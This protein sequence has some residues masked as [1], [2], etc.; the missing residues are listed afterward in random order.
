[1][2]LKDLWTGVGIILTTIDGKILMQL[3]EY[4]PKILFPGQWCVFTGRVEKEDW[5]GGTL[6]SLER[7]VRREIGEELIVKTD[8][9]PVPFSPD[10]ISL[11]YY[12][13]YLFPG[14][15]E[16]SHQFTFTGEI[17]APLE[18]LELKEGKELGVFGIEDMGRLK[19]ADSYSDVINLYLR[20]NC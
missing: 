16:T 12:K 7:A 18:S 14:K 8:N 11:F 10:K 1:M 13:P 17:Y 9:G 6:Q 20:L 4:N 5:G 2:S 3:R 15:R 19:I